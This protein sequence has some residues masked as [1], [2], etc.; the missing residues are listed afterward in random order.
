MIEQLEMKIKTMEEDYSIVKDENMKLVSS[1]ERTKKM[2][3][4]LE[5]QIKIN[6]QTK[7]INYN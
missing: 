3:T 1:V 5:L 4:D 6:Q 2:N 7:E